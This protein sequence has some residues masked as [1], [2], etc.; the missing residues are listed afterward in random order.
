MPWSILPLLAYTLE[1]QTIIREMEAQGVL[2]TLDQA[3]ELARARLGPP[4]RWVAQ[5]PTLPPEGNQ[6]L[7]QIKAERAGQAQTTPELHPE[8][9]EGSATGEISGIEGGQVAHARRTGRGNQVDKRR[10]PIKWYLENVPDPDD[11]HWRPA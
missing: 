4:K 6:I 1:A 5:E 9:A 3:H 7:D 11:E 2:L 10:D 8:T